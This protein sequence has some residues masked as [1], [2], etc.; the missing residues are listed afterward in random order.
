[1][2]AFNFGSLNPFGAGAGNS[3]LFILA[4]ILIA[5]MIIGLLGVII[6][7]FVVKKQFWI[8][9]HVFRLVGNIPTRVAI[10]SAREVP[11]GMAGDKLWRVA[12]KGF[13]KFKI[14]KWLPVGKF[15][16]APSEFWYWIRQDGEW[17]N[18][19]PSDIDS[20]SQKMNVKFVQEDMRL[21][22][23]ATDRLLE[24]R[25]MDKTFWEKWKDTIM[26]AIFFLVIAVC[27][28]LI[29]YQFSKL[30][31]K[32]FPMVELLTRSLSLVEQTCKITYNSTSGGYE[33]LI[34]VS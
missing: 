22:R 14:I 5:V 7:F 12:P 3:F 27:V 31:D 26:L 24:Q 11:M 2:V 34:P 33:G 21:Q 9:I 20:I 10:F 30:L 16:T 17:I 32:V 25:L 1:M 28:V 29:F 6:Y 8:R 18:F 19:T 13:L 15:Q 4:V 23:L